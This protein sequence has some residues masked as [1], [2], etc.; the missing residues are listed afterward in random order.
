MKE[1]RYGR[2]VFIPG[3]GNARYPHCNSL[4]IDDETSVII[5]PGSDRKRLQTLH[6]EHTIDMIFNTH[7]HEDHTLYNHLFPEA[8]LFVHDHEVAC[9]QSLETFLDYSGLKGT[10]LEQEWRMIITESFNYRERTPTSSFIDGDLFSFGSTTMQVIHT[11]GHTIGHCCFYFPG[12]EI[13]YLGDLDLTPFGPWYGDRI[14]DIDQ[15]IASIHKMLT[16]PAR[17]YISS[18]ETGVIKGDISELAERYLAV[19]NTRE[20]ALLNFLDKP[21]TFDEIVNKWI[22]YKKP[23]KPLTFFKFMESAQIQK[24]LERLLENGK[25]RFENEQFSLL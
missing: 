4:F 8:A 6:R 9:H 25:I 5:D 3:R 20:A 16:I 2:I 22:I 7:Y 21:R 18:H 15:T 1:K 23:R 13:L 24:H 11:P 10:D 12:E 19:I 17:I 14:S